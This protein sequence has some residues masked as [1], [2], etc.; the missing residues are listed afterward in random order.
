MSDDGSKGPFVGGGAQYLLQKRFINII[1]SKEHP[2]FML[3]K[4]IFFFEIFTVK[5]FLTNYLLK[6]FF[7]R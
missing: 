3:L 6:L 1:C 4:K 7:N 2:Q 5:S